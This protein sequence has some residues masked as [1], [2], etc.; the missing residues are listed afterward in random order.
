MEPITSGEFIERL[1]SGNL[2]PVTKLLGF[3]KKSEKNSEVL[4]AFK[5]D[6]ASWISIP[7]LMIESVYVLKNIPDEINP[8]TLVRLKLKLPSI[9]KAKNLHGLLTILSVKVKNYK[10]IKWVK[11]KIFGGEGEPPS[12][13]ETGVKYP[14]NVSNTCSHCGKECNCG[15]YS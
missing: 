4:F 14:R 8:L 11:K 3:V 2:K 6:M 15:Y 7:A 13:M 5:H 1:N 10:K 9:S 12:I